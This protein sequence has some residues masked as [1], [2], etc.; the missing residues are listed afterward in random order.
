[1]TALD[2]AEEDNSISAIVYLISLAIKRWADF[3]FSCNEVDFSFLYSQFDTISLASNKRTSWNC[4]SFYVK[5]QF[6]T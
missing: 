3:L 4:R 2:G 1:M 6:A 5:L